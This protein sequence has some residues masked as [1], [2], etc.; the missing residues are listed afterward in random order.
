MTLD[1]LLRDES[2]RQREFPVVAKKIFLAHAG[3]S[4]LPRCVAEAM[5]EYLAA[6]A[7]DGQEDCLPRGFVLETRQ[8]AAQLLGCMAQEIALLGPTALGLS[9]VA[10]G[11]DFTPSSNIVCYGDDYPTNV[12]PWRSRGGETVEVR[13]VR[14][15]RPGE[16]T[17]ESVAEAVDGRTRLV[18]LASAH[19]LTGFRLDIAAVGR[20]LRERGV[21]FCVD[22]IQ[23]LGALRTTVEHVDFLAADS[24][25]WLLGPNASGVL[26]VR[27]EHF[28][29]LRPTLLGAMNVISPGFI[30]QD[31]IEFAAHAGRYEPGAL[32]LTGIVGLRACLQL[33]G[34]LGIE[35]I[36]HRVLALAG[37][38]VSRLQAKGYVIVG[39]T[40]GSSMTG[41]V[42]CHK[43]GADMEAIHARLSEAAVVTSLRV[44]RQGVK[45]LRF[46]PH[47]YNTEAELERAVALLP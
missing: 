14:P 23:T 25:K 22:G 39:P 19:F 29:R 28:S 35:N 17:L 13:T 30:A 16:I 24:H 4:P 9:L 6:A 15:A 41:I 11:L 20:F 40:S 32:N 33:I 12:Y 34:D 2:L 27:R 46:S 31:T 1:E 45:L 21:L 47:F 44:T 5:R 38:L 43:P 42:S 18:A 8:L 10:N 7:R 26:F 36:E 3:T 37:W